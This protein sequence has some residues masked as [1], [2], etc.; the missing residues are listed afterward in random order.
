MKN[1]FEEMCAKNAHAQE[2]ASS[3]VGCLGGSDA[4]M[5]LKVGRKGIE[6]LSNT[7]IKRLRVMLGLEKREDFGGSAATNAGHLFEDYVQV[8]LSEHARKEYRF[9][10]M[11]FRNF[12]VIAH[13]D[14][15]EED[16]QR[17]CECKF[18]QKITEKVLAQYLAQLQWYYLFGGVDAVLLIHGTGMA[19][20]FAVDSMN[21]VQV[22]YN[23]VICQDFMNGLQTIDNWCD[24]YLSQGTT[25]WRNEEFADEEL[26]E[27]LSSYESVKSTIDLITPRLDELRQKIE[28]YMS[29][30]RI[31]S[32]RTYGVQVSYK[33]PTSQRRLDAAKAQAKYPQLAADEECWKTTQVKGSVTIKLVKNESENN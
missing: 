10:G 11:Q 13:A 7:D 23:D 20:P 19:E 6:A 18:V 4:A 28:A 31:A 12:K 27:L 25:E 22:D 24:W 32:S 3:R 30:H 26:M 5:V 1:E 29:E 17:V 16:Y 21:I 14:Y 9:D 2:I 15:Y 33:Q 8:S